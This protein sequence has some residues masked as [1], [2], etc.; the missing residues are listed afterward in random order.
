MAKPSF[1]YTAWLKARRSLLEGLYPY[2][3]KEVFEGVDKWFRKNIFEFGTEYT[4]PVE[5][6][7]R[8]KDKERLESHFIE[9]CLHK[10]A[11]EIFRKGMYQVEVTQDNPPRKYGPPVMPM[12]RYRVR[13]ILCGSPDWVGP[14][15]NPL[16]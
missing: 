5:Y 15:E 4:M 16:T 13:V 10:I 7:E 6:W 1:M 12:R 2:L 14:A 8:E 9:H 3:P 11:E